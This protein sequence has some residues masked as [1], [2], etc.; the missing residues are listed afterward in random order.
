[1]VI[2]KMTMMTYMVKEEYRRRPRMVEEEARA[3][4]AQSSGGSSKN[5]WY[6]LRS[7]IKVPRRFTPSI[8]WGKKKGK[9]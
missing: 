2:T 6:W 5:A 7:K 1:M 4:G 9:S 8:V 3:G